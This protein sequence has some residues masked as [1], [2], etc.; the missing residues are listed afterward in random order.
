MILNNLPLII[1]IIG[2]IVFLAIKDPKYADVKALAHDCFW[3]GLLA[4]LLHGAYVFI[5]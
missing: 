3:V 4:F 1:C 5:K 2:G